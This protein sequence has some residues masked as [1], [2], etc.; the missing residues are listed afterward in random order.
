MPEYCDSCGLE[1][2]V[3]DWPLCPHGRGQS[4][5]HQDS[6]EGGFFAENGFSSPRY[7]ESKKAHRDALAAEG[8]EIAAKY[9]GPRDKHLTNWAAGTVDLSSAEAFVRSHYGIEQHKAEAKQLAEEFP[10][11][12][13]TITFEKPDQRVGDEPL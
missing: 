6:V 11:T 9:A 2:K 13:T 1:I 4:A 7:F 12:V 8:K 3:G 10:I 5:V